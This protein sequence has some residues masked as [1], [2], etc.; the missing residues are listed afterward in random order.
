[1][2][3]MKPYLAIVLAWLMSVGVVYSTTTQIRSAPMIGNLQ[4][5]GLSASTTALS[6]AN[7]WYGL[8]FTPS[9]DKTL[10]KVK[11]YVTAVSGTLAATDVRCDV[12]DSSTGSPGTSQANTT[13]VTSTPTGAGWVECTGFSYALTAGKLYWIVIK[14]MNGTPASN[15]F[16]V[17][18][19]AG[20]FSGTMDA[21]SAHNPWSRK[22]TTDGSTWG[23]TTSTGVGGMRLEYSDGSMDGLPIQTTAN[24]AVGDGVYSGRMVGSYFTMPTNASV[25]VRCVAMYII[26][27]AG[28]P[29]GYPVFKLYSGTSSPTL[30]ATSANIGTASTD[31]TNGGIHYG[32]FSSSQNLVGGTVYRVVLAETTQSDASSARYNTT[33]VTIENSAGS[34]ALTLFGST[35][36]T[37][38]D[39]A[40]WTETDTDYAPFGLILDTDTPFHSRVTTP[41]GITLHHCTT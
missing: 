40:T 7:T 39:G 27:G 26:K 32:C 41:A 33:I 24:T 6:A 14:N 4:G 22:T 10:S 17:Q 20:A 35:Q 18:S 37:Y 2:K 30:M 28:S 8:S 12:Y 15:N 21:H 34:K 38:Y 19:F 1:M 9:E 29:T 5:A 36:K 31:F 3:S 11:F 25:N 16:T 23:T 13:T